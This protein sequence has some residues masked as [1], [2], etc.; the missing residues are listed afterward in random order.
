MSDESLLAMVQRIMLARG[1]TVTVNKLTSSAADP[2]KPWKGSSTQSIEETIDT[3]GMF[4]PAMGHGMGRYINQ[5]EMSGDLQELIILD[6]P[7]TG[8]DL[9]KYHIVID[10]SAEKR[11]DK[12]WVVQPANTVIA[13]I[14]GIAK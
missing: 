14:A 5:A 13:F 4:L 9:R 12:W 1:K 6:P 2:A 8:E 3:R 11:V 10:G 7:T